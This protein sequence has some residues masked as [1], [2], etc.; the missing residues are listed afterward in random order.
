MRDLPP[1]LIVR[2]FTSAQ[3][4]DAGVSWKVLQSRRFRR[5][6]PDVYVH[7][8]VSLSL[9]TWLVA[10]L[11]VMPD[12]AVVSGVSAARLWGF[13][14]SG[15]PELHVSTRRTTRTCR[16]PGV[17]LH[18]HLREIPSVVRRGLPVTSPERTVVDCARRLGHVQLVQLVEHLL[19]TTTM[20]LSDLRTLAQHR[21]WHG[22]VRT[23]RALALVREGA[24]S[25]RET[26][27]RL[28]LVLARLPEPQ[29]NVEVVDALGVFV[30]RV[31]LL[32]ARWKVVVEYDGS[33]HDTDPRQR[34]RDRERREALEGLGYRVIVVTAVDLHRPYLVVR[35][36][37][38]ALR[39][40]GHD[41][42]RP[43]MSDVWRRWFPTTA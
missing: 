1:E 24:E 29:V 34:Q 43:V 12:D 22:V 21:P 6:F 30:A 27:V 4:R 7:S 28:M 25:P 37:D 32:F 18:R 31:D 14:P 40:R 15:H 5:L 11:L 9:E 26:T 13:D 17:V 20:Q 16:L 38:D 19:R 8:A 10:V 23:R 3:A 36:V 39:Q 33:H 35:R 42:P 41:G 2:P